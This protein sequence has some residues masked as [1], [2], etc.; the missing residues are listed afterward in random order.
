MQYF[1]LRTTQPKRVHK[2]TRDRLLDVM[3]SRDLKPGKGRKYAVANPIA[4]GRDS[5]KV[6]SPKDII[7]LAIRNGKAKFSGGTQTNEVFAKWP[8]IFG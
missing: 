3:K 1:P 4:K 6:C 7:R 8:S 5:V 2:I